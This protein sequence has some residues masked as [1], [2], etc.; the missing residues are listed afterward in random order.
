MKLKDEYMKL[1][2]L[3]FGFA[4]LVSSAAHAQV[5]IKTS[6]AEDIAIAFYKK[7]DVIPN[8][9]TWIVGKPPYNETPWAMR[10]QVMAQEKLRL[11]EK[12]QN[13]DAE[14]GLIR[15]KT[16]VNVNFHPIADTKNPLLTHYVLDITYKN[17]GEETYYPFPFR[18]QFITVVPTNI[19]KFTS[20]LLSDEEY[21]RISP[22]V[23]GIS[24]PT[25]F[26]EVK[27]TI[28]DHEAPHNIDGLDQWIMAGNIVSYLLLD[29]QNNV[30][31]EKTASWY[32]AP[33]TKEL[34]TLYDGQYDSNKPKPPKPKSDP[35]TFF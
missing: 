21:A 19:K 24:Q 5:Q 32:V 10:E 34:N 28:T 27:P 20:T 26:M 18:D 8:F 17:K 3:L 6:N 25:V 7:G 11:V 15:I 35:V 12:Y 13:F 2:W 23:R 16:D 1:L 33:I 4:F 31:W 30:V 9:E 14:E 29:D 22:S